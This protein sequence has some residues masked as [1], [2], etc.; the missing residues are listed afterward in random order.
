MASGSTY[1]SAC[2]AASGG[3]A[4]GDPSNIA[5]VY[6]TSRALGFVPFV[7]NW[8]LDRYLEPVD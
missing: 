5:W 6:E 3:G 4:S 8:A 2:M 1:A 7:G